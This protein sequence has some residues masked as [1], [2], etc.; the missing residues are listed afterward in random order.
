MSQV[1]GRIRAA[2]LLVSFFVLSSPTALAAQRAFVSTAGS[3]ANTASNCSNAS[4]CRGFAAALTVTDAGGEI[5]VKDSGGY[6]PVSINKSVSL[7]APEG[8]YAGISVSTGNGVTIAT[9]GVNVILRGLTINGLGGDYGVYMTAGSS[10][11]VE[12]CEISNFHFYG[13][14]AIAVGGVISVTVTDSLLRGNFNGIYLDSGAIAYVENTKML[15]NSNDG[16]SVFAIG[17]ANT[18]AYVNRSA[19][20]GNS[21]GAHGYGNSGGTARIEVHESAL[22]GNANG[23][24]LESASGYALGTIKASQ[25]TGNSGVGLYSSSGTSILASGNLVARNGTGYMISGGEIRSMGDNTVQYNTTNV[26][27]AVVGASRI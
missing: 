22:N 26:S 14:A 27:G 10:L 18:I 19:M 25:I 17:G 20:F 3:D 9:A 11:T 13:D 7:I 8:V 23:L 16:I 2:L 1:L 12:H 15:N 4:P 24:G 21:I 5:V 6:G